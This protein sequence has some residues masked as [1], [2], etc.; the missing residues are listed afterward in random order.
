MPKRSSKIEELKF[1]LHD[2]IKTLEDPQ[3][4]YIRA[5]LP[6]FGALFG[7]DAC[8]VSWELINYESSIA[9]R[10]IDILA[11]MQGKE[12]NI[13]REEEPGKIIHEWHPN[14]AEYKDLPWPLPYYGSVD[15]TPIFIF[16]C[17]FYY[18]KTLDIQWLHTYWPNIISAIEWCVKYGDFDGDILLEYERKNPQGLLNQG[19]KDS[20]ESL[21]LQ[22]PIALIE[23]QGYYYAALYSASELA[24][25]LN[26]RLLADNLI[27]RAAKLKANCLKTFWMPDKN[28]FATAVSADKKPAD[29]ITSNP[30]HLLFS[31][32]L[33]GNED[34]INALVK[35]LFRDDMWTLWGIRTHA[36]SNKDFD[37]MS[38]HLGSVWP[39]DNWII[40][41]GLKR[42]GFNE[43]YGRIKNAMLN[44]YE[45]LGGI[46]EL[47]AVSGNNIV[48]IP[49]ACTTQAWASG[50]LLNFIL[51]S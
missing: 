3:F 50:A 39:H 43:E 35:R 4:G 12:I 14:P 23:V 18:N 27:N 30:G 11:R 45:A 46:P 20:D 42:Y 29:A 41:Q 40:A 10:A 25:K 48:S 16:L 37:P 17:G 1:K 15:S 47:Y 5:G 28:F 8:I 32:I 33:D 21:N 38:Y 13:L 34:K 51:E 26:D 22:A 2:D 36:T 19:W 7:R 9:R 31:G 44:A 24:L 49:R 6:R